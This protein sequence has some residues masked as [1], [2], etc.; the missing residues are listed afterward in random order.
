M[1]SDNS[2][3]RCGGVKLAPACIRLFGYGVWLARQPLKSRTVVLRT[4]SKTYAR[5]LLFYGTITQKQTLGIAN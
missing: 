2:S 3:R 1:Q 5:S 4:P